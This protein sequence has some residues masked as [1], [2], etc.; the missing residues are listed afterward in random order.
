MT[1]ILILIGFLLIAGLSV[2]IL[3]PLTLIYYLFRLM[4]EDPTDPL[5][6][7]KYEDF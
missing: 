7:D 3:L 2:F 6:Q 4:G 5:S 1:D